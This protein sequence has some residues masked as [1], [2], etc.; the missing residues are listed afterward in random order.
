M[1]RWYLRIS[2]SATV[3]GRNR[4]LRP[5]SGSA[6]CSRPVNNCGQLRG[7]T[8]LP[9]R[10]THGAVLVLHA[11]IHWLLLRPPSAGL[12]RSGALP[13]PHARSH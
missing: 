8:R 12:R 11:L 4:R 5:P 2:R 9:K 10:K 7:A 1:L 13:R 3:P 6:G